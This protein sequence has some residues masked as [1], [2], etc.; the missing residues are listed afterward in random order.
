M[1]ETISHETRST[2]LCGKG[3]VAEEFWENDH[4]FASDYSQHSTG[5]RLRCDG[6]AKSW[7]VLPDGARYAVEGAPVSNPAEVPV[8]QGVVYWVERSHFEKVEQENKVIADRSSKLFSEKL[9]HERVAAKTIASVTSRLERTAREAG[10]GIEAKYQAVGSALGFTSL[11]EF[12][13]AVGR[14]RPTTYVPRLVRENPEA[15]LKRLGLGESAEDIK[16]RSKRID[17]IEQARAA[18]EREKQAPKAAKSTF[19]DIPKE[20]DWDAIVES[21]V[22]KNP[23]SRADEPDT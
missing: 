13:T 22:A 16:R 2:C 9:E 1:A 19:Y 7:V 3:E 15:V 12:R 10:S 21:L 11:A 18:L 23:K 4:S 14:T 20:P 5:L 8:G 17:E 6:C